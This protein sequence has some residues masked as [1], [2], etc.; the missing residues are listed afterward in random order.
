M[1]SINDNLSIIILAAGK[2][3]RM[4]SD[5]PKVLHKVNGKPMLDQVINN[6]EQLN[7]KKIVI[8]IGY[9][10]EL[11]EDHLKE[12]NV[13]LAYQL[14]QKGT[15]H[16]VSKTKSCFENYKGNIL[17]L[18]GDVPLLTK[19]TLKELYNHHI[20]S[21]AYATVLTA[22]LNDATGYGRIVKNSYGNLEK[23]VEHKDASNEEKKINEIN[24][25][26]YIFNAEH[27]FSELPNLN[28]EN[29]QNEY[30]LPDVLVCFLNQN[31]KVSLLKTKKNIE[32]QG[33]NNI[34]QL[35][36]LNEKI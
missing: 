24:S 32:I 33:V 4:E 6:A 17:I 16:A 28:N 27:L 14:Q 19:S 31:K 2:G 1:N 18:S 12:N 34:V 21:Q 35:Q 22:E 11:L 20:Q 15:G 29:N 7:P 13:E 8:V 3:T 10:Y 9:K 5:L 26:I 36:K 25:G 30:Y 23:I